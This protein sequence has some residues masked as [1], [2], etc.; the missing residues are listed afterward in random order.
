MSIFD[1]KCLPH[2]VTPDFMQQLGKTLTACEKRLKLTGNRELAEVAYVTRSL[3]EAAP[4]EI[5]VFH[6]MMQ[7]IGIETLRILVEEPDIVIDRRE[8]GQRNPF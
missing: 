7:A 1:L 6:P 4:S 3:F 5:L 2:L 8:G